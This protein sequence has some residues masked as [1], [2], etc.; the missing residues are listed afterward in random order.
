MTETYPWKNINKNQTRLSGG[1]SG[2]LIEFIKYIISGYISD[3]SVM[4]CVYIITLSV[5]VE[6]IRNL[7]QDLI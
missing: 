7:Y 1:L 6:K 5:S 3:E 2:D 4:L